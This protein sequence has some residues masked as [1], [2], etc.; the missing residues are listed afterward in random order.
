MGKVDRKGKNKGVE[1]AL[2]RSN[3][4][5]STKAI[6]ELDHYGAAF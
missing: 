1:T 6:D 5:L 3:K 2:I 4:G